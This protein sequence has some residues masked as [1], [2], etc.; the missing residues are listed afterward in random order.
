MRQDPVHH[1]EQLLNCP[2]H[3]EEREKTNELTEDGSAR[4]ESE[5]VGT[6]LV[7]TEILSGL[8][9]ER[10]LA[11]IRAM[12]RQSLRLAQRPHDADLRV[13]RRDLHVSRVN[14]SQCLIIEYSEER[15]GDEEEEEKK[16]K[17]RR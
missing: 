5:G 9:E 16:K 1:R 6:A 4:K 12:D 3:Q 13:E 11:L 8:D 2:R 14:A 10:V 17:T 7:L 15:E